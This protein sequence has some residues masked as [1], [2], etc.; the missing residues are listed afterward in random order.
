[1]RSFIAKSR[2][3]AKQPNVKQKVLLK[4]DK[5]AKLALPTKAG[6]RIAA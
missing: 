1:M 3:R 4:V 5:G 6:Q 2:E